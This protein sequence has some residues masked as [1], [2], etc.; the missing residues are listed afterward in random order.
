M[1]EDEYGGG[2]SSEEED[3]AAGVELGDDDE[4]R[5]ASGPF[6][7]LSAEAVSMRMMQW[8]QELQ[9]LFSLEID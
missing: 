8:M 4:T 7:I 1:V 6:E 3:T 5:C 2:W 9:D